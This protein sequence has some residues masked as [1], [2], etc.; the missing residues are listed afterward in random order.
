MKMSENY[1][2]RV[3]A[4]RAFMAQHP[5]ATWED[6]GKVFPARITETVR[7]VAKPVAAEPAPAVSRAP[8]TQS[9]TPALAPGVAQL[10]ANKAADIPLHTLNLDGVRGVFTKLLDAQADGSS[11]FWADSSPGPRPTAPFRRVLANY[12]APGGSR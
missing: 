3:K 11:P 1:L 8:A 7:T 5:G 10:A 2:R 12:P 6:A 9:T 4:K